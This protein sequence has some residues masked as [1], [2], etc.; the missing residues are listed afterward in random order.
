MKLAILLALIPAIAIA[1]KPKDPPKPAPVP[2]STAVAHSD[3]A[4]ESH[5]TS[6]S[7]AWS[8]STSSALG[9]DATAAGGN[10]TGGNSTSTSGDSTS[11][12]DNALTLNTTVERSAPSIAQGSLYIG[13]CGGAANGGGS[14]SNGAGFLGFAWTPKDCKILLAAAAFRAIGMADASCEM[15]NALSVV[16]ERFKELKQA[17]PPCVTKPDP[18]PA[19]P[20]D[21][22]LSKFATKEELDRAFRAS[23]GK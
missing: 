3:A 23:V 19:A 22:D 13:D 10:A 5:A 6:A 1:G 16:K 7:G 8:G 9:G 11:T 18:V 4:S 20:R 14:N 21:P 15:I 12:A 17:P 2:V